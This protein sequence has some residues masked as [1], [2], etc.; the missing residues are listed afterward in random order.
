[1]F[2]KKLT[3]TAKLEYLLS[4]PT[5]YGK[6]RKSWPLVLFLHG[7]GESEQGQGPRAAQAR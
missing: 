5:D 6:T 7:S 1:M 3:V 2:E 4:L